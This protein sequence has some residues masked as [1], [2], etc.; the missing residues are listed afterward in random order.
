VQGIPVWTEL[1]NTAGVEP[2]QIHAP[3]TVGRATV[4][5]KADPDARAEVRRLVAVFR[6]ADFEV[7]VSQ[8][9]AHFAI[10]EL[11]RAWT[12]PI[13]GFLGEPHGD[14]QARCAIARA[15][16]LALGFGTASAAVWLPDLASSEATR[17]TEAEP[18][19]RLMAAITLSLLEGVQSS[20]ELGGLAQPRAVDVIARE[21]LG[22]PLSLQSLCSWLTPERVAAA[23]ADA[24]AH[25]LEEAVFQ[26]AKEFVNRDLRFYR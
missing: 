21:V 20:A 11:V 15:S 17:T 2:L 1:A 7:V 10:S 8:P 6:H 14:R 22:F 24:D 18:D 19:R 4:E 16:L 12:R 26:H 5:I 13:M 3:P 25:G 23:L 9:S